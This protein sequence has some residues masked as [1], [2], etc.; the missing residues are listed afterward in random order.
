MNEKESPGQEIQRGPSSKWDI[1]GAVVSLLGL[2]SASIYLTATE[3]GPVPW[4]ID[5]QVHWFDGGHY[6]K[7]TF[8]IV[9][10][11][12]AVGFMIV[13]SCL[14]WIFRTLSPKS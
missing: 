1:V 7:L 5:K 10:A 13:F 9:F 2:A 6:P 3:I 11:S 8:L 14:Q 12:L 4:L